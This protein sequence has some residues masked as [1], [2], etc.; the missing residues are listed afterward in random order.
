MAKPPRIAIDFSTFDRLTLGNGQYRYVVDLVTGLAEFQD[1]R[2]VVLG[3]RRS[4]VPELA[5]ILNGSRPNWKYYRLPSWPFRGGDYAKR[6][7]CWAAAKLLRIDVWHATGPFVVFPSPCPVVVTEH[8]MMQHLFNEYRECIERREYRRYR[9]MV[10]H[11]AAKVICISECT[12][13]DLLRLFPMPQEG[14]EVVYHGT[15]FLRGMSDCGP[16]AALAAIGP[17]LWLASPYNLE[18][19]KN[20]RNLLI[21][22][23]SLL[24]AIPDLMLVLYGRAAVTPEREDQFCSLVQELNL[25]ANV[26]RTGYLTDEELSWVYRNCTVFAFPSLY[27][28]FGLPVLEAMAEGACVLVRSNSAM[29]EIVGDAAVS[30]ETNDAEGM[31]TAIEALLHNPDRRMRLSQR[32]RGQV[33]DFSIERMASRTFEVYQSAHTKLAATPHG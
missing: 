4:P 5:G 17:G 9:S 8:D 22:F 25:G 10:Q 31:A 18:P 26:I 15:R 14:V 24:R 7:F 1:A 23:H 12:K 3:S 30:T 13:R 11:E 32:A 2:F 21:A 33:Q 27:E 6:F 19:R 29:S 20:L 16:P 28:G